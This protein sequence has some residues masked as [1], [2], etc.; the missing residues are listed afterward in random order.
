MPNVRDRHKSIHEYTWILVTSTCNQKTQT[1]DLDRIREKQ[2]LD[3]QVNY[4][5][6]GKQVL[7]LVNGISK[8]EELV[9]SAV[10]SGRFCWDAVMGML[11][12]VMVPV[13]GGARTQ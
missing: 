5:I 10:V 11:S 7:G 1:C 3:L 13:A 6:H 4:L 2:V 12:K 9:P 8:I